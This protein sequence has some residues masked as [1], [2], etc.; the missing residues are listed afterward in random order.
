MRQAEKINNAFNYFCQCIYTV[1]FLSD[2]FYV[3][4]INR[5]TGEV[6]LSGQG[7]FNNNN[8]NNNNNSC[9]VKYDI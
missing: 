2:I 9:V 6:C 1:D 8:N 4:Y 7:S 3:R 5:R